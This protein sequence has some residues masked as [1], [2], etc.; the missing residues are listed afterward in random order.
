[1]SGEGNR[2]ASIA[3]GDRPPEPREGGARPRKGP[4]AVL[5][6]TAGERKMGRPG[7]TRLGL[8]GGRAARPLGESDSPEAVGI[9]AKR[10]LPNES[11]SAR[12]RRPQGNRR[13][14]GR[15]GPVWKL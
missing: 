6:R 14:G 11:V 15:S 5:Q 8:D 12:R 9:I 2:P 1:M 4:E 10:V 13:R 7:S 3:E